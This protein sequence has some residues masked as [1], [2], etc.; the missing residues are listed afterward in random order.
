M[1][2]I[3]V[4]GKGF[5]G[6][7]IAKVIL[8][9]TDWTL[10]C[11]DDNSNNSSMAFKY[12]HECLY[13]FAS[14]ESQLFLTSLRKDFPNKPF[15]FIF[16][17]GETRVLESVLRPLDFLST[18]L[19]APAKFVID[20]VKEGDFFLFFSTAGALYS[21]TQIISKD[22]SPSPLNMYG[23]SKWSSEMVL[24]RLVSDISGIFT[25]F[26]LTNVYGSYSDKKVSAIHKFIKLGILGKKLVINGNGEQKRNFIFAEDIGYSTLN[27]LNMF[28]SSLDLNDTYFLASKDELSI[29]ELVNMIDKKLGINLIFEHDLANERKG[30][31]EKVLIDPDIVDEDFFTAT[32]LDVGIKKTFDF[33]TKMLR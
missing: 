9:K 25:T 12:E 22:L 24:N 27:I 20:N 14:K 5:I 6:S 29:N 21:G 2:V 26:R 32:T 10:A 15:A 17:A 30:E 33:Y 3:F 4:G 18:N 13:D 8:S 19:M 16:L 11:I 7:N 28:A 1:I 23:I 31:P